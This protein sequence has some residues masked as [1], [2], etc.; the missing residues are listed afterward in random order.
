MGLGRRN[1][2]FL[3]GVLFFLGKVEVGNFEKFSCSCWFF[4]IRER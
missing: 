4:S 2:F 3:E 1:D